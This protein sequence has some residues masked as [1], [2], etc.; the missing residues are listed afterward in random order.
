MRLSRFLI[1]VACLFAVPIQLTAQQAQPRH[2]VS[3]EGVED[4]GYYTN[5]RGNVVHRPA[6]ASQVPSGATAVCRDSTYSFS[7]SHRGT[8]SHHGGVARWL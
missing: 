3:A 1:G 6:H 2:H 8:C 5:S 4:T 7:Q